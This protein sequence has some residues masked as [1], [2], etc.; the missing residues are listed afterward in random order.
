MDS[1]RSSKINRN[2]AQGVEVL[3]GEEI[4]QTLVSRAINDKTVGSILWV[5]R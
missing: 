4:G 1:H 2:I 3:V 5:V